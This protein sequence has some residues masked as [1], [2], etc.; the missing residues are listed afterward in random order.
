MADLMIEYALQQ[1]EESREL[2]FFTSNDRDHIKARLGVPVQRLSVATNSQRSRRR[3]QG[4]GGVVQEGG[5]MQQ[6]E[7]GAKEFSRKLLSQFRVGRAADGEQILLRRVS[8]GAEQRWCPV[9]AL[10]IQH[11]ITLGA[12]AAT[13]AALVRIQ[14]E[15][16]YSQARI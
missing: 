10:I 16:G 6:G 8:R 4:A 2:K 1:R 9:V 3:R 11:T 15:G 13:G 14:E 12:D 7:H 5:V